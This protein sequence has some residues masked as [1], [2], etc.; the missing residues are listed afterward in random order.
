MLGKVDCCFSSRGHSHFNTQH[1]KKLRPHPKIGC[2]A[3]SLLDSVGCL[4]Y[5]HFARTLKLNATGLS[6][7]TSVRGTNGCVW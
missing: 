1:T 7:H 2:A 6:Y 4:T 3:C 5:H